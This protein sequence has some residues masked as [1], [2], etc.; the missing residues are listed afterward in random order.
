MCNRYANRIAYQQY[1][2]RFKNTPLRIVAP[3][4]DKAP[5]LEPR[6]D[7][8]PTDPT[9]ILRPVDG[10]LE[11]KQ[12]RWGLIPWFHKKTVKEWK[13]LTTNA[14]SETI[15]TT[16][17]FK[18][19]F[20]KHRCLVPANQ[21]YEWTGPKGKKVKWTFR[22]DSG[23]WFCFAGIWE[24][25]QTAEGGIESFAL[26]TAPG[27]EIM[28]PFHDRQP[29]V[30]NPET[31]NAWLNDEMAALEIC[32]KPPDLSGFTVTQAIVSA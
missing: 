1:V 32:K 22:P 27:G 26:L 20:Q 3:S 30:L 13:S 31:Y 5:N 10:G 23:D 7:I 12:I 29:I 2:E 14:R 11:L 25:A 19:A 6:N 17:T 4:P 8:Y 9:S 21:F 18:R 15:T 28:R 24:K 16:A